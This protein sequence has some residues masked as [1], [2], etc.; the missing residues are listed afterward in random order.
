VNLDFGMRRGEVMEK[1]EEAKLG[2]GEDMSAVTPC[3]SVSR[4]VI[5]IAN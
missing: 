3:L 2:A 1:G 5:D 4:P